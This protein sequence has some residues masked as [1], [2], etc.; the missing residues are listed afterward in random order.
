MNFVTNYNELIKGISDSYYI[1]V[2]F[3]KMD[4]NSLSNI[5]NY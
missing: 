5:I 3:G 1:K 4:A 2:P